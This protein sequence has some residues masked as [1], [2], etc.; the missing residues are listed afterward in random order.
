MSRQAKNVQ[1]KLLHA[2]DLVLGYYNLKRGPSYNATPQ[3]RLSE[4]FGLDIVGGKAVT[5]KQTLLSAIGSVIS[6]HTPLKR[7]PDAHFK[8]FVCEGLKYGYRY[9]ESLS[10]EPKLLQ[11][12]LSFGR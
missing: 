11:I 8:A 3:R 10:N 1:P 7:S 9:N 5:S 4:S 6:S 2:W 12:V